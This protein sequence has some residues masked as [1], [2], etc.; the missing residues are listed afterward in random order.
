MLGRGGRNHHAREDAAVA[1]AKR[2]RGFHQIAPHAGDR[3]RHHQ[4][5][6]EHRANEDNQQLLHLADAG[7]QDQQ[8]DEG[9]GR[10][11]ARERHERLEERLDRLVG[12]HQ[13]AERHR[14]QRREHE[15]ADHAP[16]GYADIVG[17]I[18]FGQQLRAVL[19]HGEGSARKVFDTWPPKVTKPQA[20]RTAQ[21]TRC[22]EDAGEVRYGCERFHEARFRK[23]GKTAEPEY[24][25]RSFPRERESREKDW[26]PAFAGTSGDLFFS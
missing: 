25:I 12:A 11:I 22:P 21:R 9:R 6:L 23:A 10:Q 5:D 14:D 16:D 4:H 13:D 1:R 24:K 20:R 19:H 3:E 26:V 7:P 15:A 17:E 2:K 18:V 8:R